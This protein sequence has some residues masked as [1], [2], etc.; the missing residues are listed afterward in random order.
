M[1]HQFIYGTLSLAM[2]ALVSCKNDLQVFEPGEEAVAVYG[3]INP[4]ESTQNIRINKVFLTEG[5][6][7]AAGQDES[8]VNYGP[9]VLSVTLQRFMSGSE[10]PTLTTVGNTTKKEIVLTET[11]VTTATGDFS[12]NQRIWQTTD[13]LYNSGDY[14]LTIKNISTGKEFTART[15]VIDS[16]IS[17][18]GSY[19]P[20]KY[21]ILPGNPGNS[22]PNHGNY[23]TV[24]PP[25]TTSPYNSYINYAVMPLTSQTTVKFSTTA[26]ARLYNL[27]MRFHYQDS[28]A[29]G[30]TVH[31]T[32]DYNFPTLKSNDLKG[33]EILTYSFSQ[34][35]F[36]TNAANEISKKNSAGVASRKA[37]YMEYILYSGN[38][39]LS[40]FLQVNAPS[41]SI[42]QDKP[43]YSNINGG[44]GVF[45]ARARS[46]ISKDLWS[47]FVDEIAC[48]ANTKPFK[49]KRFDGTFCP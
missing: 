44:V 27:T 38:Q 45:S 37:L 35:S 8:Q 9:G 29:T 3:I 17:G 14:K 24:G 4:N 15:N 48:N 39:T 19:M 21:Y 6:A 5:D 13:K 26:N 33:G 12:A 23:V 30:T 46:S 31:Q 1:K 49:F 43:Y 16:V 11:V 47:D 34:E 32:V 2:L 22:Y 10:T 20:L 40:D 36:Y 18:F 41:N 25:G 28:L 7:L 42:A